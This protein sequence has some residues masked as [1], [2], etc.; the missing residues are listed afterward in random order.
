MDRK[1]KREFVSVQHG[2]VTGIIRTI[3]G[4]SGC[5][6]TQHDNTITVVCSTINGLAS[7]MGLCT[8]KGE[9]PAY[10]MLNEISRELVEFIG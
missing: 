8:L 10:N 1:L 9:G 4:M 3:E 2:V 7:L 6:V 5:S